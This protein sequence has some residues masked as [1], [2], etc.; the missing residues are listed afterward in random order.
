M[1]EQLKI[2][3][4][5]VSVDKRNGGIELKVRNADKHLPEIFSAAEKKGVIITSVNLRKPS[6]ED[7]YLKF[8][9]RKIREQEA[10]NG[11]HGGASEDGD[12]KK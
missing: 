5:V 3:E 11:G 7:V 2:M 12:D 10:G 9:G 6:L 8:T 1:E 4:W